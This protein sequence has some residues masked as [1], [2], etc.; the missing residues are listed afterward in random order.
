MLEALWS[1]EFDS[2]VN[3]FGAGV[4]VFESGRILG[5]DSCYTYVGSYNVVNSSLDAKIKVTH[6]A[7]KPHSIFGPAS[8]FNLVLTGVPSQASFKAVGH[9]KENPELKIAMKLTRQAELP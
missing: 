1:V 9:V 7:G 4:A 6:Y 8:E 5:G 3:D 2:N